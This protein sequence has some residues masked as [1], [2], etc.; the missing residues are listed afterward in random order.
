MY[1]AVSLSDKRK[2]ALKVM[3]IDDEERLEIARRE[4]SLLQQLTHPNIVKAFDFFTFSCGAV[5]VEEFFNGKSLDK[6]IR[7]TKDG[8]IAEIVAQALFVHLLDAIAYLHKH[9]VIHRDVKAQN[10]LISQDMTDLRLIDFNASKRLADGGDLLT[11]TGTREYMPPEVLKGNS[12]SEASDV[13]ASGLCFYYMLIGDLPSRRGGASVQLKGAK[14]E[15][16]SKSCKDIVRKCLEPRRDLRP[17]AEE[18]LDFAR[19]V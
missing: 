13:W 18:V 9:G 15:L 3:R 5:L 8:R 17:Q 1:R 7:D 19:A 16:L 11:M 2:V 14:W 6:I 10:M 12:P 4:Y